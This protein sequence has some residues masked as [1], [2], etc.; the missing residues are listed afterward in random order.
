MNKPKIASILLYIVS[1]VI[2]GFGVMYIYTGFTVGLMPYHFRF[3]GVKSC[4][5]LPP[6]VC[7][8]MKTFVQIVGFA[9][10]AIGITLFFLIKGMFKGEQTELD[11]KIISIML[12]VLVPIIFIMYHLAV[13]TPWYLVA[14]I[15]V[16]A[17]I[18]LIIV[19]PHKNST[20]GLH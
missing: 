6:N 13:Y 7:E 11:W 18:A 15:L 10:L 3:L 20:E 8:L 12:S 5:E 14:G 16:L 17:L 9:F 1:F 4:D 2:L 19:R